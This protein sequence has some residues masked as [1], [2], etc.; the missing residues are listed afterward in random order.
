MESLQDHARA[1]VAHLNEAGFTAYW[2]GGCV[3]DRILG[4]EPKDIDIA[5][6][7]E[8]DQVLKLFPGALPIGRQF[9]V[10]MV[11]RGEHTYD[12]ATFRSE[13]RYRDGRHPESVEYSGPAEDARRRDFTINGM[14]YDPITNEVIDYIGGRED[15]E[16]GV[17]RCIGDPE[18]RFEEDHLRMLRAVRFATTLGFSI[19]RD[20]EDAVQ[21]FAHTITKISMERIQSEINRILLESARP[22]DAIDELRRLGLL[23]HIIPEIIPMIGQE[24]PPQFH[25]EGDVY[26]HTLIM[27]NDMRER[28]LELALAVLLHDIG[29]PP[30]AEPGTDKDGSPRIRFNRH[31]EVGA[32]MTRDILGRMKYARAT[33]KAVA[34]CVKNHMRFKDVQLMRRSKL[35]RLIAAD[36]FKDELELHR[37]DCEASHG[38][39]QNYEYLKQKVAEHAAQPVLPKCLIGGND[40]I[41]MGVQE[42]PEIGKWLKRAHDYQLEHSPD[43]SRDELL[44]WVED[45]IDRC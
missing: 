37:L 30:T 39:L 45:R 2:A 28:N 5:T 7:A 12:V 35:R 42:G 6:S 11:N 21:K 31:A 10:I 18:R 22:G 27:L 8:P 26:T 43:I 41:E 44:S 15:I 13:G 25:P 19:D 34:H 23:E 24:Q 40:L 29:K 32:E 3:R 33:I 9:G 20:T 38:M 36:T 16:R 1:I 4:R 17:V 14:F